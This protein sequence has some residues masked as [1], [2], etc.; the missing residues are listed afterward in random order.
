[1]RYVYDISTYINNDKTLKID[2]SELSK[3]NILVDPTLSTL[4][5]VNNYN[6]ISINGELPQESYT[7]DMTPLWSNIT[8]KVTIKLTNN[9]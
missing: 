6:K 3:Y 8:S 1:M 5:G 2:G 4:S 9:Q 7:C